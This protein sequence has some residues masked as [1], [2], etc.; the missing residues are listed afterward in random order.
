MALTPQQIAQKFLQD[1]YGTIPSFIYNSQAD[2]A[3]LQMVIA[4]YRENDYEMQLEPGCANICYI[5]GFSVDG[6]PNRDEWD[7]FNDLCV[8]FSAGDEDGRPVILHKAACTTEP[9]LAPTMNLPALRRGGVFRIKFGQYLKSWRPGYHKGQAWH[10][11]LVQVKGARIIGHRDRNR[12]GFRTGDLTDLG[13]GIN[14][15][16]TRPGLLARIV[17]FFSEGCQVHQYWTD[18]LHFLMVVFSDIRLNADPEYLYDSVFIPGN[19]LWKKY[20]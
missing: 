18:Y 9:G 10:P 2:E 8:V 11:A 4:W 14:Q 7:R 19:E 3:I 16:G 12:D 15:H 5:E 13:T 20:R 17:G 1:N 6:T